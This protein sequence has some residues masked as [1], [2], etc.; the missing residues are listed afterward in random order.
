M[1]RVV[2]KRGNQGLNPEMCAFTVVVGKE[3]KTQVEGFTLLMMSTTSS[4]VTSGR[5]LEGWE[6]ADSL[7]LSGTVLV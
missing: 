2:D 4:W 5:Q 7:C 1:E 3:S 6:M